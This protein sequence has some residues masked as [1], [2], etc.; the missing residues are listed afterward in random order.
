[1]RIMKTG[2][3]FLLLGVAAC[4][5]LPASK[6]RLVPLGEALPPIFAPLAWDLSR[7]QAMALFPGETSRDD[8]PGYMDDER[9]AVTMAWGLDWPDIGPSYTSITHDGSGRVRWLGIETTERRAACLTEEKPP[10]ALKCRTDYGPQ[11][12][13]VLDRL[14]TLLSNDYGEPELY[15]GPFDDYPDDKRQ[16][17]YKWRRD[18]FDLSLAITAGEFGDWVVTLDARRQIRKEPPA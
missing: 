5:D 16:R 11:L 12:T 6:A 18:G 8:I 1:M 14:R 2:L 13:V 17:S 3:L 7:A 9:L 15:A 4:G 10:E